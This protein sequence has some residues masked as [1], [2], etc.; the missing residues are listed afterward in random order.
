MAA[1]LGALA[2]RFHAALVGV[3]L[4]VVAAFATAAYMRSSRQD[5]G[6]TSELALVT[7]VL[8]GAAALR[9]PG[10]VA[11]LAVLITAALA[12]RERLHRLVREKLSTIELQQGLLLLAAVLVILPMLPAQPV[13]WLAGLDLR[14]LWMLSVLVMAIQTLAHFSQRLLGGRRGLLVAGLLGGFVSSTATIAAMG[15][16]ARDVPGAGSAALGGA[17]WSNL[18]TV[19]QMA[20][21]VGI[22]SPGLLRAL[23]WPLVA[24]GGAA[25]ATGLLVSSRSGAH[26]GDGMLAE[27]RMFDPRTALLFALLMGAAVFVGEQLRQ[28]LGAAGAIMAAAVSG[29]ADAHAAGASVAQLHQ[30]GLLG[31]GA[32]GVGVLCGMSSNMLSKVLAAWSGGGHRFAL[33]VAASLGLMLVALWGGWIVADLVG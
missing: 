31:M 27:R 8:L 2:M 18:A 15:R 4:L 26:V 32:S 33:R 30:G 22:L 7:T 12:A 29:L 28:G 16:R 6:L 14:R 19:A 23:A 24:A 1:L 10:L 21:V 17:L 25:L 9:S 3:A 20:V 11:A 5:P 13:A